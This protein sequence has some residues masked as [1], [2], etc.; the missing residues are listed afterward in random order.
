MTVFVEGDSLDVEGAS[1]GRRP[2]VHGS[3]IVVPDFF[4]R[5]VCLPLLS[6]SEGTRSDVEIDAKMKVHVTPRMLGA[7]APKTMSKMNSRKNPIDNVPARSSTR[8]TVEVEED[9]QTR[10]PPIVPSKRRSCPR[11]RARGTAVRFEFGI[12]FQLS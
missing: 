11:R 12:S 2:S 4:E 9:V 6:T 3:R 7:S 1:Q 8:Q 5:R 10:H